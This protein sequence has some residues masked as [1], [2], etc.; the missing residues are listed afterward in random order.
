MLVYQINTMSRLLVFKHIFQVNTLA[1]YHF[2]HILV[3]F[4]S[5]VL[6]GVVEWGGTNKK[7]LFHQQPVDSELKFSST[8][9]STTET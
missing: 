5:L 6:C 2:S 4:W 8:E 9:K 7:T 1:F 3:T